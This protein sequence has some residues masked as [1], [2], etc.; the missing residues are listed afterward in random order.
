MSEVTSLA[1]LAIL[2]IYL[3]SCSVVCSVG[4]DLWCGSSWHMVKFV[5]TVFV[6][7]MVRA[8]LVIFGCRTCPR[9]IMVVVKFLM[10][11][12]AI[13]MR[14]QP[15]VSAKL[16]RTVRLLMSCGSRLG[17]QDT[18]TSVTDVTAVMWEAKSTLGILITRAT[19]FQG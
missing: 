14:L 18:L 12:F 17:R 15:T 8:I 7:V 1:I 2:A 3:V 11:D 16:A 4:L 5:V 9:F 13:V 19:A 10:V 6:R